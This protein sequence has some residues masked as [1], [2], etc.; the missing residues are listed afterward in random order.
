M[1]NNLK[2]LFL[3]RVEHN[4]TKAVSKENEN[5]QEALQSFFES[6]NFEYYKQTNQLHVLKEIFLKQKN[7]IF[8]MFFEPK[9]SLFFK[10]IDIKVIENIFFWSMEF[11]KY[12]FETED[13]YTLKALF[14]EL[15]QILK[16]FLHFSSPYVSLKN[17]AY[18]ETRL[19]A[20]WNFM[21][22]NSFFISS[23]INSL[24]YNFLSIMYFFGMQ[25]MDLDVTESTHNLIKY[26]EK[27]FVSQFWDE[28]ENYLRFTYNDLIPV[29]SSL[30]IWTLSLNFNNLLFKQKRKKIII[31]TEEN[32]Y[33]NYGLLLDLRKKTKSSQ[34][35]PIF[36]QAYLKYHRFNSNSLT[37]IKKKIKSHVENV[38]LLDFEI[39][40]FHYNKNF[41][42]FLSEV[43]LDI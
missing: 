9:S 40:N 23:Y 3:Q 21:E 13:K 41:F 7:E 31:S 8:K 5:I 27:T 30:S 16:F 29:F 12:I 19:K 10:Y 38:N 14:P 25:M 1:Q 26:I 11:Y 6:V 24:W 20:E 15:K 43:K 33:S 32:F 36:W 22:K 18:L 17:R 2:D 28:E 34:L 42:N 35:L 37:Y 4:I 39:D